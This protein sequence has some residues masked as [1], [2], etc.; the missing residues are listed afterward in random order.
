MSTFIKTSK[1]SLQ[2]N[3]VSQGMGHEFKTILSC[4]VDF[5]ICMSYLRPHHNKP[6]ATKLNADMTTDPSVD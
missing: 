3:V 1:C 2:P 4:A 6:K 5:R